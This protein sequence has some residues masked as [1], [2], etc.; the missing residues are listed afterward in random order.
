[1]GFPGDSVVKNLPAMLELQELQVRTLGLGLEDPLEE[2]MV[3]HFDILARF[4]CVLN[5]QVA[6]GET[7]RTKI[8]K[9]GDCRSKVTEM[10]EQ[11]NPS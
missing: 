6:S 5:A 9:C 3:T 1:M 10:Q 11:M 7:E 2:G 4:E 8:L